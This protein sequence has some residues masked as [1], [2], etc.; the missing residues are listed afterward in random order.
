MAFTDLIP[1]LV[2]PEAASRVQLQPQVVVD[3]IMAKANTGLRIHDAPLVVAL[4]PGFT[5]GVDCHAVI[6]TN[7]GHRLGRVIYRGQAEADTHMPGL[8]NGRANERVLRAPVA[9][10]VLAAVQVGDVVA[11]DQLIATVDGHAIYAPFTGVVRGLI[12]PAVKVFPGLKIGDLGP[13]SAI[14][15]CFTISDK[16]LAIGGGVLEAIFAL[17]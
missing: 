5:A 4:G 6:E 14:D 13:R 12:H 15:D 1:V 11:K 9:G 17:S 7:R 2:D 3:A 16:S 10:C 8:V